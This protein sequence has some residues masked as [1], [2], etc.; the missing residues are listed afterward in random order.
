MGG[1]RGGGRKVGRRERERERK[2]T[3]SKWKSDPPLLPTIIKG[4]HLD[5][6]IRGLS[7]GIGR[8]PWTILVLLWVGRGKLV[9]ISMFELVRTF[10]LAS[11]M[12]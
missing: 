3:R 5:H 11:C 8:I 7:S 6:S 1:E 12:L 9:G 4:V 10:I 2:R